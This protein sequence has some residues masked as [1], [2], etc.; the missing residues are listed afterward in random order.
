MLKIQ[1]LSLTFTGPH[2]FEV[3]HRM[4]LSIGEG[5][6]MGLVGESGSGKTTAA[7][8]IAGLLD[9][10]TVRQEGSIFL[11]DTDLLQCRYLTVKCLSAPCLRH[12]TLV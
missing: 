10:D 8:A 11:D 6:I 12:K 4:N 2:G 7:L 5:E 1:D 9:P 3:I